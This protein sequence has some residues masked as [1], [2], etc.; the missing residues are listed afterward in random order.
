[1]KHHL[2]HFIR[3]GTDWLFR[4]RHPAL[5][6][7]RAGVVVAGL[8]VIGWAFS[9]SIPTAHGPLSISFDTQ[10]GT[11][12]LITYGLFF[13]AL[14]LFAFG[15]FWYRADQKKLAR[16]KVVVIEVRGLRDTSG[17]PLTEAVPDTLEGH[18]DQVLVDLR[19]RLRDGVII[20][21]EVALKRL[22]SLPADL[23]RREAGLDRR[24]V[25]YIYGGLAP[26]PLTFLTGVLLD[27]EGSFTIMDWDR[28]TNYWRALDDADDGERFTISGLGAIDDGTP[29]VALAISVSYRVD[30]VGVRQ[31]LGEVP[32]VHAE[33]D[34]GNPDCHWSDAKQSAL[35]RQFLDTAIA[36]GNRGVKQVHLFLAAQNSLVFRFGR[37]YDKRNL[38]EITV[39][40]YQREATPPFPWAIR[41]PVSGIDAPQTTS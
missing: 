22:A 2:D 8:V 13:A 3:S 18:R 4:R 26:V 36:L 33:L 28:H 10:G 6:L 31:K 15:F 24:D 21:P 32:L 1:V 38:P 17:T 11:P 14:C 34:G 9:I 25:A 27:D 29:T 23:A 39:Y 20:D 19:Q 30:L 41:M 12:A 5:F 7:I 35:G 40:Q 37:L 16:K